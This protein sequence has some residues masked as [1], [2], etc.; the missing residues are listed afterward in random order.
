MARFDFDV[1]DYE[2][3]TDFEIMPEGTEV[4]MSAVETEDKDCN[5]GQMVAC[6]F[7]ILEGEYKGRYVWQNF[8]FEHT[9]EKAVNFGRRMLSGWARA[10]GKPN[11]KSTD[12]LLERPFWCKLGIEKGVGQ[13]KDKNV[14]ASFL[15]PESAEAPKSQPKAEKPASTQAAKEEAPAAKP[16]PAS[17]SPSSGKKNPWDD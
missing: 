8:I 15:M 5:G 1:S 2:A 14:I 10:C 12:E 16:A 3:P 9:S 17:A 6:K 11:A 13:Y 4:R 7:K